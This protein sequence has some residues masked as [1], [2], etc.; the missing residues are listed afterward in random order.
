MKPGPTRQISLLFLIV[1]SL[2]LP[3]FIHAREL[4]GRIVAPDFTPIAGASIHLLKTDIATVSNANGNF[5]LP[6]RFVTHKAE[7]K[8][9]ERKG[10]C[11]AAHGQEKTTEAEIREDILRIS[12]CGFVTKKIAL[13][14]DGCIGVIVLEPSAKETAIFK[15]LSLF[16]G[17]IDTEWISEPGPGCGFSNGTLDLAGAKR[18]IRTSSTNQAYSFMQK[19]V[20]ADIDPNDN[21][22]LILSIDT[23]ANLSFLNISFGDK[24]L[25]DAAT[26]E[27]NNYG[28]LV[29]GPDTIA[30]PWNA[31]A[32][33]SGIVPWDSVVTLQIAVC[34]DSGKSVAVDLCGLFSRKN[35]ARKAVCMFSF[36]DGWI[37]QYTTAQ[38]IMA[39]HGFAG[40]AFII[41]DQA[42]HPYDSVMN[43]AQ[44]H[45]LQNHG[46]DI[47]GLS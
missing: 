27:L 29:E 3:Q 21:L 24:N 26:I 10:R 45:D 23:L 22:V 43:I 32:D 17:G 13:D 12:K 8:R 38:P 6:L 46:W 36:D 40:T 37:S 47:P 33:K 20:H 28:G 25:D 16:D 1:F 39:A 35:T 9:Y 41:G 19:E 4:S 18:N 11:R 2:C 14:K 7:H 31:F 5:T 34:A 15:T 30:L 44:L 42:A